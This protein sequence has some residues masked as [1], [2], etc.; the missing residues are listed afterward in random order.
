MARLPVWLVAVVRFCLLALLAVATL[1]GTS[2]LCGIVLGL[3]QGSDTIT[4][5]NLSV[6]LIC[7]LIVWLFVATFHLRKE[8][9]TLPAADGGRFLKH[10]RLILTEMGYEVTARS[11]QEVTTQPRFQSLLFGDGVHVTIKGSQ[12]QLSGPKLNVERLRNR[13]RIQAHLG[14]V[15]QVLRDPHRYS[16]TLIKRAELHLRARPEDLPAIQA[17][18]I[19]VLQTSASVICEMHL[20]VQSETGIPESVLEFQ[21]AEWLQQKGIESKLHKHFI[22]LHRPLSSGDVVLDD[23]H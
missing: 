2:L 20:L 22:Q 6:G 15:R 18:V 5:G 8:V 17:N 3:V 12:A 16:Q 10:A 1:L 13:L 11:A 14:I 4:P 19:D 23:I 7:G 9:V 21:I